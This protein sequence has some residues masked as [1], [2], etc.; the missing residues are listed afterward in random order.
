MC[1][2]F[3]YI[4]TILRNLNPNGTVVHT[5]VSHAGDYG[6]NPQQDTILLTF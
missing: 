4:L 5:N 6:S 1:I 3:E 2:K